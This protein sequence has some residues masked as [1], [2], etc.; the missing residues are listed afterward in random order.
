MTY[1]QV[2]KPDLSILKLD[3]KKHLKKNKLDY[4][5]FQNINNNHSEILNPYIKNKPNSIFPLT[6]TNK[7]KNRNKT[8]QRFKERIKLSS[9]NK[10]NFNFYKISSTSTLE[11]IEK[12][13]P[14][15]GES[16]N[17]IYGNRLD[18]IYED[19]YV[20]KYLYYDDNT[21]KYNIYYE[22]DDDGNVVD[23][24]GSAFNY[25]YDNGDLT[26][27]LEYDY[28]E[29][30]DDF[31]IYYLTEFVYNSDNI[32]VFT[33]F[34]D[35]S[36]GGN[37]PFKPSGKEVYVFDDNK[38]NIDVSYFY[39]WSESEESFKIQYRYEYLYENDKLVQTYRDEWNNNQSEF[40]N[41]SADDYIYYEGTSQLKQY[42]PYYW[43]SGSQKYSAVYTSTFDYFDNKSIRQYTEFEYDE[44]TQKFIPDFSSYF[45]EMTETSTNISTK[46][47]N[48]YW[49]SNFD[50]WE[51]EEDN[52]SSYYTKKSTLSTT[53]ISDIS[54]VLYPNPVSTYLSINSPKDLSNSKFELFDVVGKKVYSIKLNKSNTIN[55][56]SL[57]PSIYF[58]KISEE[59]NVLKTG[60]ILKN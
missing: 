43:S 1:G 45:D 23:F 7:N 11:P 51:G 36:I 48:Y 2:V 40:E 18:S 22:Y 58:Y 41:N 53:D 10:S 50:R 37:F 55:I 27:I 33:Y 24:G 30:I 6:K 56:E 17:D 47:D 3:T 52:L 31:K 20:D 13:E 57:N 46:G 42:T 8:K 26:D 14:Y 29:T 59:K 34:Y 4:Q 44:S 60:S 32:S 9:K 39:Y 35:E 21:I 25:Y 19:N 16:P 28:D 54:F 49:D 15:P 38:T 5:N 12:L